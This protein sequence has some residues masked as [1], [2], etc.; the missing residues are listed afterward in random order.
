MKWIVAA[1]AFAILPLWAQDATSCPMH[2]N[3]Q[4]D[5]ATCPMH[6]KHQ[7]DAQHR[8]DVEQHGDQA[9]GFSHEKTTH[10]FRLS[11]D[12][13]AIEVVANSPEDSDSVSQIRMHMTHIASMF[14]NGD[15]SI[16]MFVHSQ[17]PPGTKVMAE[18][19]D[20][21]AYAYEELPAGGQVRITTKDAAALEAIHAFLR[22]QIEDH[23]TGDK[24][25]ASR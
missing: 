17:D 23:H 24:L 22:F 10:H 3:H 8:T 19:R 14:A 25:D 4:Q 5:A 7:Q 6:A 21:I 16:P 9:M 11:E 18:R 13:G 20:Q 12:G 1:F 2:T 15:F